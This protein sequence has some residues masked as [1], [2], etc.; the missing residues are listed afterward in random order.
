MVF[1]RS[2]W[3]LVVRKDALVQTKELRTDAVPLWSPKSGGGRLLCT[4]WRVLVSRASERSVR[5]ISFIDRGLIEGV[6]GS[7]EAR[8]LWGIGSRRGNGV[9][10]EGGKFVGIYA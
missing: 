10:G 9:F 5:K 7:P 1:A 8:I 4:L 3:L 2:R 6:I